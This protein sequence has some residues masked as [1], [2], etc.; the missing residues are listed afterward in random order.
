[1]KNQ[2]EKSH[3]EPASSTCKARFILSTGVPI[4][5]DVSEQEY[6]KII[7]LLAQKEEKYLI[8]NTLFLN[9]DHLICCLREDHA[10]ID[11]IQEHS[12][13]RCC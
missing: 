12:T 6:S 11:G 9:K 4:T 13:S 5:I 3:H 7:D 10:N 2:S 8:V 1:M